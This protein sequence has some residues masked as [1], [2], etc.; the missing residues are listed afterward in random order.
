M[1]RTC[2]V[3]RHPKHEAIDAALLRLE[4]TQTV[5]KRFG[6]VGQSVARH[7]ANHLAPALAASAKVR[8]ALRVEDLIAQVVAL[9][10]K[11]DA[12]LSQAEGDRDMAMVLKGVRE[13]RE[14]VLA[15]GRLL[16]EISD[17]TVTVNVLQAPQFIAVR[18]KIILALAKWPEARR[19]VVEALD[20]D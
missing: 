3:C 7:K 20:G 13:A 5:A 11:V 10:K 16:G 2:T 1:T 15:L 6:L 14:N 8:D 9:N 18:A 19:A 17:A 4:P 12:V